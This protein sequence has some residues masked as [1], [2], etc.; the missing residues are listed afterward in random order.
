[1]LAGFTVIPF[2]AAYAVTNVGLLESELPAMYAVGGVATLVTAQVIG[3]LADRF[4]KKRVYACVA[5]ASIV[6][7]LAVT[8]M[9]R[10]SLAWF[11]PVSTLFFVLVPGRFGPA[12][13]LMSLLPTP[14]GPMYLASKPCS[15]DCRSSRP[16]FG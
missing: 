10:A 11:L 8:H 14:S 12:M 15:R 4:G 16:S 9:P 5:V 3:R 13:A 6:P 2:V 7:I 1:M